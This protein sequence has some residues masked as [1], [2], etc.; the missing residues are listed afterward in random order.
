[1]TAI[2]TEPE[3]RETWLTAQWAGAKALQRS[4]PDELMQI[5]LR[6]VEPE[7]THLVK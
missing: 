1:M 3:E 7:D 6:G 5:V 2:L 4:L